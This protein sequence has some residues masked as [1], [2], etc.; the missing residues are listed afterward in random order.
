MAGF[1]SSAV[2]ERP[3]IGWI[4]SV[5]NNEARRRNLEALG[6]STEDVAVPVTAS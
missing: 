6:R 3:M 5:S 2:K 1:A 4:P